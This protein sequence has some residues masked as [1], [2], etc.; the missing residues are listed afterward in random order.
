MPIGVT[1]QQVLALAPDDASA[2]AARPLASPRP[3]SNLGK[4]DRAIWGSCQGSGREPYHTGVDWAGPVFKCSCPSRKFPCKHALAMLLLLAESPALFGQADPPDWIRAWI[5]ARDQAATPKEPKPPK[6]APLAGDAV[7]TKR[8][9]KRESRA[10]SGID[11][12]ELWLG[13]LVQHGLATAP[14]RGFAFWDHQAA[15][16]IDAQI[17]GAA[18]RVRDLGGIAAIGGRWQER[19]LTAIGRLVL[20]IRAFRRLDQLPP[21]TQA[22]VRAALGFTIQKDEILAGTPVRDTWLTAAQY[23]YPED[24]VRVQRTWLIGRETGRIAMLLDFAVGAAGFGASHIPGTAFSGELCFY[25][26]AGPVRAVVKENHGPVESSSELW[27]TDT[28][29][30]NRER[31]SRQIA[32]NPW[33]ETQLVLLRGV[34]PVPSSGT[35]LIADPRGSLPCFPDEALLAFSGGH[36]VDLAGE[37]D[38]EFVRPL[39]TFANGR[40]GWLGQAVTI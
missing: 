22:D 9:A 4:D 40:T 14:G 27:G 35:W 5:A 2:K 29:A 13:D 23:C 6:E 1:V 28:I 39:A 15:R 31:L 3:W 19:M 36:P 24:R 37:W 11:A 21:D 20:L 30:A 12:L 8:A 16:L 34:V 38:G 17:P 7:R 26:G 33:I 18:R 25:P 32:V 10:A